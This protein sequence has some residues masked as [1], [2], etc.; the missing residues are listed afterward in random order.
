MNK[1]NYNESKIIN[2]LDLFFAILQRWRLLIICLII[3][4]VLLGIFGWWKSGTSSN[5]QIEEFYK[6]NESLSADRKA[7]LNNYVS[8]TNRINEA[9]EEQR[10]YNSSSALM[11]LD[12][13][14]IDICEMIFNIKSDGEESS[15]KAAIA[16]TYAAILNSEN[17]GEKIFESIG[18]NNS[19]TNYTGIVNIEDGD[20][21]L[22]VKTYLPAGSDCSKAE[23]II[24][25][26]IDG[27]KSDVI[28][29]IGDHSIELVTKSDYNAAVKEVL[30]QQ[31]NALNRIQNLKDERR[32]ITDSL[33]DKYEKTYYY[34][35]LEN[36]VLEGGEIITVSGGRHISIK[37]IFIGAI[38]GVIVGAACIAL[39]Y[40]YSGTVKGK[41]D[42][43][44][45]FNIQVLGNYDLGNDFNKKRNT[46]LDK[47]LKLKRTKEILPESEMTDLIAAKLK[48]EADKDLSRNVC[49]V[50]DRNVS[51]DMSVMES[52]IK[53]VGDNPKV[54]IVKD[55]LRESNEMENLSGIDGAVLVAQVNKSRF[56]DLKKEN[57]L[58]SS[59][60]IK[61]LGSIVL[62]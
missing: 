18:R 53:K 1:T 51:A 34:V 3:G 22:V 2:I 60:Q 16:K 46:K 41:K 10:I 57:I 50:I 9:I 35:V 30:D 24:I 33:S 29:K 38:L 12:P 39:K 14:N 40:I 52:I 47:W 62:E 25:K 19:L 21:L 59:Y 36:N 15:D 17:L 28:S 23:D 27:L 4:A 37:F 61:V 42:I 13:N 20:G 8:R 44:D 49:I 45:N 43:E 54:T 58:C 31:D 55:I 6:I 48:L 11:Q 56:D 26:N 7:V 32:E 5:S